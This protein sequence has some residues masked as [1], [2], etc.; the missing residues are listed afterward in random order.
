LYQH[1]PVMEVL[2]ALSIEIAL[3]KFAGEGQPA[4]LDRPAGAPSG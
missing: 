1:L 3:R 2:G 4:G